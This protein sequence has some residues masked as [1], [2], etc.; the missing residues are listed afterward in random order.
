MKQKHLLTK[1]ML[2]I[3]VVL[4]GAGTAWAEEVTIASF[5]HDSNEGWT[6]TNA[7]YATA[8]GGYY[9]LISSDASIVTPSIA[10]SNYSDITITITARKFGG[11]DTTQGKI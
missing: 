2:L 10:W 8:T 11:P 1:M 7:D 5:N 4:M 3:A 6:I 9:K